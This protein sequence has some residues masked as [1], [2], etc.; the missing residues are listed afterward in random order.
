MTK[1]KTASPLHHHHAKTTYVKF[2][3]S[4]RISRPSS[5]LAAAEAEALPPVSSP[6]ARV[7]MVTCTSAP[8]RTLPK[9]MTGWSVVCLVVWGGVRWT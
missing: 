4:G 3:A 9:R 2:M 8:L 5:P 7:G 6:S 1:K